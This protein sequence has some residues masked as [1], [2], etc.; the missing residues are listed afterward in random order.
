MKFFSMKKKLILGAAT[1]FFFMVSCSD[2][3]PT[4]TEMNSSLVCISTENCSNVELQDGF[5]LIRSSGRF[6]ELGTNL[7]S[8]KANERP[9]MD[10]KFS[11]DFQLGRHE[12]TCSEFNKLMGGKKGVKVDCENDSLP[13]ANVTYYD[14]I[15]F[16][17][18]KSKKAGFDTA[19]TYSSA[20]FDKSG[21]C[22]L[23][24]GFALKYDVDAFRL[25][26]EAEWIFAASISF[27][28]ENS[29]NAGTSNF[30]AHKVCSKKDENGLCDMAGNVTEWVNDWLGNFRDTTIMNYVGGADGGNLGERVIK[31]GSFR[32]E[33][34]S[35]N[36]FA[37]GDV[38]T[39]TGTSA[40]DYL[41]FR[42]AY[43]KIENPVW[44]DASGAVLSSNVSIVASPRIISS[45]LG[46]SKSKLVFRN[47]VSKNLAFVDF[48]R[49]S[50]TVVEIKDSIDA[51][52]PDISP[53][54]KHVAFC[55]GQ[56]GSS[57]KSTVYVRDLNAAG[58]N[59]VKLD[60]KSAA[61][62]RWRVLENGDTVIVYVTD[63]GN[64]KEESSFKSASTWQVKFAN[65]K[66][67][68]PTKL[69]DGAYHG[70]ISDDES[71]SVTGAR[72]LRARVASKGSNVKS[73]AT[74]TVWYGGDQACNASL[75]K[76]TKQT[77]FLDF[78]GKMGNKFV[79]SKYSA[80]ERLFI[81]NS[82]GKLVSSI[83]APSGWLFDHSEW[84]LNNENAAVVTLVNL[85]GAHGKIALVNTKDSS[86]TMLVEGDELWHPCLWSFSKNSSE[87]SEWDEDSVGHY[88]SAA[89]QTNALLA[90]KMPMFWKYKDS[91]ELVGL[92]NS[93]MWAG[94]DPFEMNVF[95]INMG[96]VPCDM[97]CEHFLFTNYVLNHC[98]KVK[99][100]V[101]GLDF[102]LWSNID[103][104]TDINTDM[105]GALG[106][107]Y[108]KNHEFYP[109]GVDDKFVK[110]V[111]DNASDESVY[112]TRGWYAANDNSGWT[113]DKGVADFG[114]ST[115]SDC[116]LNKNLANCLIDSDQKTCLSNN[117]MDVCVADT[118][119]NMCLAKSE[120]NQCL[121]IF[122]G[123]V[124]K[125]KDIVRLAQ[126]RDI[127][128]VGAIFPISPY[129]KKTGSYGRHG[130]R[131][132]HAEKLIEEIKTWAEGKS[133]FYV[134]DENKLGN[135]DYP[136]SMANDFDHLNEGGAVQ[137]SKRLNSFIKSLESAKSSK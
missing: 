41:G 85:Y 21:H 22:I 122:S 130:M 86:V 30:K 111:L 44:L 79:G 76:T 117:H 35:I 105:G 18:A 115:W 17:N 5:A 27:N 3:S 8:A 104:R 37:R 132:S 49:V 70:G 19:Y 52:H 39:V 96:V 26:T 120:L 128:V 123:D 102:D 20:E 109:D 88:V 116:L 121:A 110:I 67:G 125:L 9:Q 33:P 91:V 108:D 2:E 89:N 12:V 136:T 81:M 47:D 118:N 92:G 16:A 72:L 64:N 4:Q 65:G 36:L 112:E 38:Y 100:V 71:L 69:F 87:S 107:E 42:L 10:V 68:K 83:E 60:V 40:A 23:L 101:L 54:G 74:D 24:N 134:F 73:K 48:G 25:P 97:H 46:N 131:R 77:L 119:L 11:Y 50:P 99:Y 45:V 53:D 82:E 57:E 78:S 126:E 1:A 95:S 31:G 93:H 137:F 61:V 75:N 55:T 56:E 32:S 94:F 114:D 124:D 63:A 103:E 6:A 106:F 58:T 13:A 80:H 98:P 127:V 133:N 7:K 62:P 34:S 43:G 51:Y 14:A 113:N 129:Y 90:N 84:V 28:A 66:F 29:W 15:L 135:H 59:L